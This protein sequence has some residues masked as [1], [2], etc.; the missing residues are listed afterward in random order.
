LLSSSSSLRGLRA[1]VLVGA[2]FF[3]DFLATLAKGYAER[4]RP[5]T[6]A[7]HLLFG[8]DSFGFPSGHTAR[9][10]ALIGALIWV[11]APARI[12]VPAAIVGAIIGGVVMGYARVSLGVHFPTDALGG[13][14]LGLAWLAATAALI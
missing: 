10:A 5:D 7:A 2:T 9:A 13:L 1:G 8:S 14:L 3:V 12:R 11:F 4:V 6:P